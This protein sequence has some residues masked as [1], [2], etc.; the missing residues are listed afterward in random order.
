[1]K[2]T[3][4]KNPEHDRFCTTVHVM[5]EWVVDASGAFQEVLR[6]LDTTREPDPDNLWTCAVCGTDAKVTG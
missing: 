4:P 6:T 3:C 1:M 5:E 2:A